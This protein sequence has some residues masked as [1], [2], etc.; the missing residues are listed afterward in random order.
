M[1]LFVLAGN[2]CFSYFLEQSNLESFCTPII[3]SSHVAVGQKY[4]APQGPIKTPKLVKG[5]L[6]RKRLAPL[7]LTTGH[8]ESVL[9]DPELHLALVSG[10]SCRRCCWLMALTNWA[11]WGAWLVAAELKQSLAPGENPNRGHRFWEQL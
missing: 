10:R 7:H 11:I 4:R 3:D 5:K 2:M 1:T 6:F 8:R 9:R